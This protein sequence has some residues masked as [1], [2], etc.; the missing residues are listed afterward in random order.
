MK[1]I[2]V[3]GCPGSGKSTFSREL[4]KRTNVPIYHLDMLFW[5]ADKTTVEKSVFIE[6]VSELLDKDEWIIDGNFGSTME[7]R[8]S[9]CD[10]VI[11]LDFPPEICLEGVRAR[12]G[13]PRADIPWIET[14]EDAEFMDFIRNFNE[15]R[16]PQILELLEKFKDKNI[17]RFTSRAEA[18]AYLDKIV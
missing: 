15:Q 7:A 1:K 4:H 12:R 6:R 11:F 2:I 13:K 16:R 17:I 18:D 8:M 10:T 14:E 9:R 5:N 3:I